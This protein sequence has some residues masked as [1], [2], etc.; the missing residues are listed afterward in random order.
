[1]ILLSACKYFDIEMREADVSRDCLCLTAERARSL[2]DERTIG[3]WY[4]L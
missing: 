4:V 3:V 2:I 1:M